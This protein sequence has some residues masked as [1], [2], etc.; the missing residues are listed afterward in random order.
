[1]EISV[2]GCIITPLIIKGFLGIESTTYYLAW[3]NDI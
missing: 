2:Y 3:V 1:M